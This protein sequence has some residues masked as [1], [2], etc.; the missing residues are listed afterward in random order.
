MAPVTMAVSRSGS[1]PRLEVLLDDMRS[2]DS[3]VRYMALHDLLGVVRQ[4][5][6]ELR[7]SRQEHEAVERVLEL[8]Q[9]T[10]SEVKNLAVTA[11][12]VFA[13]RLRDDHVT[14]MM[15]VVCAGMRSSLEEERDICAS[16]LRTLLH[17]LSQA[18]DKAARW[19][20]GIVHYVTPLLASQLE[21]RDYGLQATALSALHDVLLQAGP[22][23]AAQAPLEQVVA[24]TLLSKLA[25]DHSSFVRRAMQ[26]LGVL[27]QLC[28][29]HTY[30]AV[31]ERGLAGQPLSAHTSVQLLGVLA[32]ETPQ[33]L[34]PHVPTYVPRVLSVLR[35][36]LGTDD[37][38]GETCLATL[39]ALVC[40]GSTDAS[41]VSAA[42]EAALAALTYDPNAM[43]MDEDDDINTD[44]DELEL[45][46]VSDDDD[47]SWR[48]RRAACRV[49]GTLYEHGTMDASHAPHIAASLTDRLNEREET[50][51]LEA[52]AALMQVL[53]VA[54]RALGPHTQMV[55]ALSSWRSATAQV[56]AL[57]ALTA[58]VASLGADLPQ[59]DTALRMALSVIE[60]DAAASHYSQGRC[61]AGLELL[62]QMCLSAPSVVLTDVDRVSSTLAQV[63]CQPYHRTALEALAVG[64][65]FFVHVAPQAPAACA[66]RLCE[67]LCRPW[68]H[69][70]ALDAS[71]VALDAAL[72]SVGPRL[73]SLPRLLQVISTRLQ[74]PVTRARC[75]QVVQD[76]MTCRSLQTCMPVHELGRESL[77]LLA[78]L[79]HH[80]DMGAA[81]LHALHSVAVVLPSDAQPIVLELLQRPMP[82]LDAPTL[83][84]T[85]ALAQQAVQYHP[86]VAHHVAEWVLPAM[87]PALADV[88]PPAL[89]AFFALL[90][91]LASAEDA[92]APRLVEALEQAWEAHCAQ[93]SVHMPLVFA[94]CLVAATTASASIDVV[95]ARVE[96]LMNMPDAVPQTLAHYTIGVLG[97]RSLLAG[98]P[99]AKTVYERMG[100]MHGQGTGSTFALGGMLL[101]NQQFLAPVA[102]RLAEDEHGVLPILREAFAMASETQTRELAPS[103]WSYLIRPKLLSAEPDACTECIARIVYADTSLLSELAQLVHSQHEQHRAMALGALR[104]LLS[105]DRQQALDIQPHFSAF[106]ER[107][108]DPCL[109]VRHA[110]VLALHAALNSRAALVMQHADLVLPL[111]YETTVVREELKR[112][113]RMGPFTVIQD[114]G[115][116]LR[117][118]AHETLFTLVDTCLDQVRTRDVLDC[119]LRALS[120]DDSIKLLGCLMILRLADLE[121]ADVAAY[122]DAIA[123]KLHAVL[124]RKLRDNATKQEVEK[125][126]EITHASLRVL[127]RLSPMASSHAAW[128]DLLTQTRASPQGP[129]FLALL[130]EQEDLT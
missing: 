123:P 88:P 113:V 19:K 122:L 130:A 44:D 15:E 21:V 118:N 27:C 121:C 78:S 128:S 68:D 102:E 81:A 116:D 3:D 42:T 47:M 58:L 34:S 104:T 59:S 7:G 1:T 87:L 29:A 99:H 43:D 101:G 5:T 66:E 126:S 92:L 25:A 106:M 10:H 14:R 11:L 83:P 26:G 24:E 72:C 107:L 33:R 28:S 54:P 31:L 69:A 110:S 119:V 75:V 60:D 48:I 39:Q 16:A 64:P 114:D 18:G 53:R 49:L 51:R 129:A 98:W 61:M 76:V 36:A 124:T 117:K 74:D 105:L 67:V 89:E 40:I 103:V 109:S 37:D 85:L 41:C 97:Q 82:P 22:L 46:D 120:D 32:R 71:L 6:S 77:P 62:K 91:S 17:D 9:D 8:L 35:H 50:V 79:A 23:V 30:D 12:G 65:P 80:R 73:A 96:A 13:T 115:L 70:A 63:S 127:A 2:T 55:S 112:S 108:S 38:V 52:L 95:L 4:H 86:P 84:P 94:Q 93:R 56:A 20:E 57:Q 100:S 90:T 111:L 125:A 45:D